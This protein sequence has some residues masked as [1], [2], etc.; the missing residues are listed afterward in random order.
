MDQAATTRLSWRQVHTEERP[1]HRFRL[2]V[3]GAYDQH[4]G[5]GA[6][7][8]CI[9]IP[10]YFAGLHIQLA[11]FFGRTS[12]RSQ[13]DARSL[14]QQSLRHTD[15]RRPGSGLQHDYWGKTGLPAVPADLRPLRRPTHRAHMYEDPNS[16]SARLCR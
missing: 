6:F 3:Y 11:S 4:R 5:A 9:S 14:P 16:S 7:R 10:F 15:E 13:L 12:E 8:L 2:H 1:R